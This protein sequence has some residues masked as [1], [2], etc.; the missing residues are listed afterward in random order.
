MR[1]DSDTRRA[2]PDDGSPPVRVSGHFGEW[3]QGRLGP[4]GPVALVTVACDALAVRTCDGAGHDPVFVPHVLAAFAADLGIAP[5]WCGVRRDMPLGAGAGASTATLVALARGAGF[6][7]SA[8]ARA[9][10]CVAAEGASDPLMHP[11]CDRLIWASRQGRILRRLPPPPACEIVGGFWG[12]PLPTQADD[13]RFPDIADLVEPWG[14][15]CETADLT[16]AA[17][18]A[19]TSAERSTA[20]RGPADDPT[21]DLAR[22]LGAAGHLRAHTG[23]ARGLLF[24]PGQVPPG[25]EAA[26]AEAGLTGILRFRTGGA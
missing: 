5:R 23:S 4:D 22:A 8:G 16:A 2:P 19:S 15:A 13:D 1:Q 24:A 21:P 11:E 20:L 10:A 3:L 12:P 18:V 17:R 26:L 7:G 25:A 14:H 9:A 6:R